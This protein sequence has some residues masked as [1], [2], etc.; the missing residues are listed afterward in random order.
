VTYDSP[1]LKGVRTFTVRNV[2]EALYLCKT[3]LEEEGTTIQTRNG[4][5]LE[6]DTPVA[7]TYNN[8][9][10]RVLFYP[11]RDAN[12]VFHL[13]ESLWMLQGRNDVD[14]IS[15]FN[16]RI[17]TYSDDGKT[18][19]GAYGHRW[20]YWFGKDQLEHAVHRLLTYKNDRRTVVSMWDATEDLVQTNDGKDYPCN[21]QI[22][23]QKRDEH[24]DMTVVNRS[25]DMIWGALG[26]NAVHMSVLQEY[27]A[28]KTGTKVGIYTQFSNNFHA[29]LEPLKKLENMQP[30]YDAYGSRLIQPRP[31]VDDINSFDQELEQF[32]G[33]DSVGAVYDPTREKWLKPHWKNSFFPHVAIKMLRAWKLYKEKG[34]NTYQAD[35]TAQCIQAEDWAI[36]L[37][38]WLSRRGG[39]QFD[40]EKP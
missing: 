21:T 8:P 23:F 27:M 9:C 3:A 25:N 40:A 26:A 39:V 5:A 30:D 24:L 20:R 10:E 34:K 17:N 22:Y 28:A 2:S 31:L 35:F 6:F 16:G 12:P 38:E 15:Q 32:F 14:W 1:R 18:F 19:H 7:I 4:P 36:A 29:Y 11:Q 13:M 33:V 37:H